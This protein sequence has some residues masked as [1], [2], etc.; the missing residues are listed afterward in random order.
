MIEKILEENWDTCR[1]KGGM[2][3]E[4]VRS[5]AFGANTNRDNVEDSCADFFCCGFDRDCGCDDPCCMKEYGAAQRPRGYTKSQ[6]KTLVRKLF[7]S[8]LGDS[9]T[10]YLNLYRECEALLKAG[11]FKECIKVTTK[12]VKK[13]PNSFDFIYLLGVCHSK[14]ASTLHGQGKQRKA[15]KQIVK[16]EK[17]FREAVILKK[18]APEAFYYLGI[19]L[20]RQDK[21]KKAIKAYKQALNL[22]PDFVQAHSRLNALQGSKESCIC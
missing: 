1:S 6:K 19:A 4:A 14:Y 22:K 20:E 11:R 7:N 3:F 18:D 13:Y 9:D 12:R 21:N 8:F 16:A 15:Q 2:I 5:F 10:E 17:V